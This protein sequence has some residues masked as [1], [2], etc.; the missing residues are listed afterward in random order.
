MKRKKIIIK[1]QFVDGQLS[2]T[3]HTI[4]NV[5]L[6]TETKF[7]HS[8]RA[9]DKFKVIL[10]K[11]ISAEMIDDMIEHNDDVDVEIIRHED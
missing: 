11:P 1:Q 5:K 3:V 9:T 10:G 8:K 2:Y 4:T 6:N 7:E